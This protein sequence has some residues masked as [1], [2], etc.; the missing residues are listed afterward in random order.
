MNY[1]TL[2]CKNCGYKY[3]MFRG[4]DRE[5]PAFFCEDFEPAR[6]ASDETQNRNSAHTTPVAK[7]T[8]DFNTGVIKAKPIITHGDSIRSMTDEELAEWFYSGDF[9]WCNFEEDVVPCPYEEMPDPCEH[10]LLDWLREE[11]DHD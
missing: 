2:N 4:S 7:Y 9:P 6:R 8:L 3:C 1:K 10:C 5:I 11:A